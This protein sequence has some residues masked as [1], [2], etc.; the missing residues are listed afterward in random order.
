MF[1][2]VVMR[3]F[4][5]GA[6]A[7]R[8]AGLPTSKKLLELVNARARSA[9]WGSYRDLHQKIVRTLG[10]ETDPV[11]D[12]MAGDIPSLTEEGDTNIE[13]YVDE[14]ERSKDPLADG[15]LRMVKLEVSRLL[16][17]KSLEKAGYFRGFLRLSARTGK[18]IEIFT[19]NYD[20][21]LERVLGDDV[22]TGFDKRGTWN[23]GCFSRR[24]PV[25]AVNLYKMHGSLNWRTSSEKEIYALDPQLPDDGEVPAIVLGYEAKKRGEQ[26]CPY[27]ACVKRFGA[28]ATQTDEIVTLGYGFLDPDID[29]MLKRA[30]E[31][32]NAKKLWVVDGKFESEELRR[33]REGQI[34]EKLGN[35]EKIIVLNITAKEFLDEL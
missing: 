11:E 13:H 22:Q 3:I 19:L 8:D 33:A 5:L 34:R 15:L 27:D 2:R 10:L 18:T 21:C 9:E 35:G 28:L 7:S 17:P 32:R 20:T 23:L 16:N 25:P 6:G 4:L 14:L 24:R 31:N 12:E 26:P 29:R 1:R 30:L